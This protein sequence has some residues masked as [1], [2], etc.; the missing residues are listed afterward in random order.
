VAPEPSEPVLPQCGSK[1][2]LRLGVSAANARH[3]SAP[4]LGRSG[5][6]AEGA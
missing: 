3:D 2:P 5:R 1:E 4:T 6:R